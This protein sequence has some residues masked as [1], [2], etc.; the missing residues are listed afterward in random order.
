MAGIETAS[1]MAVEVAK[2]DMNT[3]RRV[4]DLRRELIL[5]A[6]EQLTI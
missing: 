1:G 4:A 6:H 2:D 5:M 3:R